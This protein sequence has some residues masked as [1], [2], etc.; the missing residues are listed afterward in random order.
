M[1]CRFLGGN[2]LLACKAEHRAYM[3]S[4]FEIQE[5]CT[6]TRHKVCPFYFKV[7]TEHKK[8]FIGDESAVCGARG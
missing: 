7:V 1:K 4:P 5:Y 2:Y 8:G 3:P 6:T